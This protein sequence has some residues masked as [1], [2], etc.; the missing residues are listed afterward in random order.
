MR[1]GAAIIIRGSDESEQLEQAGQ[2]MPGKGLRDT[3]ANA[4]R[5]RIRPIDVAKSDNE[6]IDLSLPRVIIVPNL[7]RKNIGS[8]RGLWIDSDYPVDV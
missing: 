2:T 1:F 4:Q 8:T 6:S 7:L 5:G 3:H